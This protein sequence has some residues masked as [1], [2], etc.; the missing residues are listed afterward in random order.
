MR[1]L[2]KILAV[3][4]VVVLAMLVGFSTTQAADNNIKVRIFKQDGV[5]QYQNFRVTINDGFGTHPVPWSGTD[6]RYTAP[7]NNGDVVTIQYPSGWGAYVLPS[8]NHWSNTKDGVTVAS[9]VQ[10]GINIEEPTMYTYDI[11]MV[12]PAIID[13]NGNWTNHPEVPRLDFVDAVTFVAGNPTQSYFPSSN[14]N[15]VSI[16]VKFSDAF[17]PTDKV[18]GLKFKV[19]SDNPG[20][21]ITGIDPNPAQPAWATIQYDALGNHSLT[22]NILWSQNTQLDFTKPLLFLKL[23]TT[24]VGHTNLSISLGENRQYTPDN[25]YWISTTTLSNA[26]SVG[27]TPGDFNADGLIDVQDLSQLA[28]HYWAGVPGYAGSH[29]YDV[30]FDMNITGPANLIA[31]YVPDNKIEFE[32]LFAFALNW[33]RATANG[34]VLPKVAPQHTQT[35]IIKR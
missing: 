35:F 8:D 5:T 27:I 15:N 10:S 6:Y 14:F 3:V 12:G 33:S 29:V 9:F 24:T 31:S 32:D 22:I 25:L 16:P 2:S 26:A 1:K 20:V 21:F 4:A 18:G 17:V 34:G 30:K 11:Y 19:S 28:L 7:N 13:D 23:S